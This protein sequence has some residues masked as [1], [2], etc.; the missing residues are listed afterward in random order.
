MNQ[1]KK[2]IYLVAGGTGGH[3][4]PALAVAE[5]L[6]ERSWSVRIMVSTRDM[7]FS[8]VKNFT[9]P[10]V[11]VLYYNPPKLPALNYKIFWQGPI[12][13]YRFLKAKQQVNG[14]FQE[15]PP[16]CIVG[17]GGYVSAPALAASKKVP[18]YIA[19][20]NSYLGKVNRY[21][22]KSARRIFAAFPLIN[23]NTEYENK[24]LLLGNPVRKQAKPGK[25]NYDVDSQPKKEIEKKY[26]SDSLKMNAK[27]LTTIL[28]MGGSQGAQTLNE[29]AFEYIEHRDSVRILLLAGTG[30]GDDLLRKRENLPQKNKARLAILPFVENM[31]EVYALSD[32]AV[33]RSGGSLYELAAW[34]I[35]AVLIPYP[36][37]ADNHQFHNARFF[38]EKFSFPVVEERAGFASITASVD[39]MLSG[40]YLEIKKFLRLSDI[41]ESENRIVD[42]LE[43][44]LL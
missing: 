5:I 16:S 27:E 24:V 21:F 26:F 31:K 4:S 23:Q 19:E 12:F 14:W 37:A 30:I 2:Y 1:K 41:S 6:L 9:Q 18:I 17:F 36:Y 22:A 3:I 42:I 33:A 25:D 43:K 39:T 15:K 7:R 38:S 20:Q 35:P 32:F 13:L 29:W 40:K 8:F 34:A 44:D 10:Q 28:I 11:E